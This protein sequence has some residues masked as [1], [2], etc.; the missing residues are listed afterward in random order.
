MTSR[1]GRG[2]TWALHHVTF[3]EGDLQSPT[4]PP[5]LIPLNSPSIPPHG[6]RELSIDKEV[7]NDIHYCPSYTV[8]G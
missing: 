1:R 7:S 4:P 5:P 2:I 3:S 6:G 8:L